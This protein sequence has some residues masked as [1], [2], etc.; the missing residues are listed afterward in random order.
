MEVKSCKKTAGF[1][2]WRAVQGVDKVYELTT[3]AR[4]GFFTLGPSSSI[5]KKW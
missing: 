5:M 1:L 3:A 2:L 4:T